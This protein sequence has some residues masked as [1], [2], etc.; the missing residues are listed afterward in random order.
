MVQL[1]KIFSSNVTQPTQF[2]KK[3]RQTTRHNPF[4]NTLVTEFQK[5]AALQDICQPDPAEVEDNFN[6]GLYRN[7]EDIYNKENSQRQFFTMPDGG[8]PDTKA[9]RDFVY[10]M[11]GKD[12]CKSNPQVCTG[13]N[14]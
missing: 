13:Y 11:P 6:T 2:S 10:G 9:F 5:P 8:V 1:T 7:I 3:C 4:Q 14:A 12:T